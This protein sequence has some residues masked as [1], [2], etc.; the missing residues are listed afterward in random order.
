VCHTGLGYIKEV[1]KEEVAKTVSTV[2]VKHHTSFMPV[3]N[4]EKVKLLRSALSNIYIYIS[5]ATDSDM[6]ID[7]ETTSSS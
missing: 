6:L 5:S 2:R 4:E 3:S 1:I 7:S